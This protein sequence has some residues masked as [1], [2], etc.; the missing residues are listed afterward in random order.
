MATVQE[1]PKQAA[2][3]AMKELAQRDAGLLR[4]VLARGGLVGAVLAAHGAASGV[5][6]LIV[7]AEP[8]PYPV[9]YPLM[10]LLA[11][12]FLAIRFTALAAGRL[13]SA[14]ALLLFNIAL[15]AFW[16]FI[17][18]DQIPGRV[19]VVSNGQVWRGDL[20]LLWVPVGLYGVSMALLLTHAITRRRR[21]A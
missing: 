21:P 16:C 6:C 5:L 12:L 14:G 11:F 3:A 7:F 20:H 17:L 19:V 15:T 8:F 13:F 9:M 10:G 4:K 18:V 1:S 2:E